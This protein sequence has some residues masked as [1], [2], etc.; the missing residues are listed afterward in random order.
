MPVSNSQR[1]AT[2]KYLEGL[3]EFKIRLPKGYK[4]TIKKHAEE[5]GESMNAFFKR[6]VEETIRRDKEQSTLL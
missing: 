6:A 4:E 1:K 3:D 2:E 5:R